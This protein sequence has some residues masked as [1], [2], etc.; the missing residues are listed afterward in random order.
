[1]ADDF[2][3]EEESPNR[4]FLYAVGGMAGLLVIAIIAIVVIALTGGGDNGNDEIA[5]MNQT[6]EAQNAL[7][8]LTV[9]A[10]ET[11]A[12]YS[13]TQPPR[14][15]EAPTTAPTSPPPT[16][17]AVAQTPVAAATKSGAEGEGEGAAAVESPLVPTPT[18]GPAGGELPAGGMGMWGAIGA[19]LVLVAI[20]IMAR[21]LRPA[22]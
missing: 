16:A 15:T 19:A 9:A 7:V 22:L 21:R 17:T 8:T 20:I 4:T 11:E 1:M 14:A 6:I 2:I 5:I 13:P 3:M 12:A 10:M 18:V